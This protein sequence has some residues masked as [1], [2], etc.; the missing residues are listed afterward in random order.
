MSLHHS[1]YFHFL[2]VPSLLIWSASILKFS[3]SI[4]S[5]YRRFTI[6]IKFYSKSYTVFQKRYIFSSSPESRNVFFT[7][8]YMQW[9]EKDVL[10]IS[11][12][13]AAVSCVIQN[14]FTQLKWFM[15]FTENNV[16]IFHEADGSGHF[17][18]H[19][20]IHLYFC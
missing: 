14:L 16:D 4:S 13:V 18:L 9:L 20:H 11:H 10:W 5:I 17:I 19:N 2:F 6:W 7:D 8:R 12:D 15:L 1:I 3:E